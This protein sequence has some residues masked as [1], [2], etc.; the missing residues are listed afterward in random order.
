MS[1]PHA[2]ATSKGAAKM[3]MRKME[4][5]YDSAHQCFSPYAAKPPITQPIART[6]T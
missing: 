6:T 1:L 2:K 3:G 5:E 4:Y